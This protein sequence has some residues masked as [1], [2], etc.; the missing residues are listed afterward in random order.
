MDPSTTHYEKVC[1]GLR[2]F[3]VCVIED[4][5]C[6]GEIELL[7]HETPLRHARF[8]DAEKRQK[9]S[10]RNSKTWIAEC[11][12]MPETE[13]EQ[14]PVTVAELAVLLQGLREHP[15]SSFRKRALKRR[16][17]AWLKQEEDSLRA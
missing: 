9:H 17:I 6:N 16:V 1:Q 12:L 5:D 3:Y 2:S 11:T 15:E 14:D 7:A 13:K 10:A 8:E 4:E